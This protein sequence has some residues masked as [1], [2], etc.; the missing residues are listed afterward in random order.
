[1]TNHH[2]VCREEQQLSQNVNAAAGTIGSENA[3]LY[4]NYKLNVQGRLTTPEEF[5]NIILRHDKDGSVVRLKDVARVEV[6]A[7]TYSGDCW[8]DR[9]PVVGLAVYRDPD[10]NALATVRRVKEELKKTR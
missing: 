6:G 4:V 1:M 8:F 10:A 5:G 9:Q 2:G 3:N 7:S